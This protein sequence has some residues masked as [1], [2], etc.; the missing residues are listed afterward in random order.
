VTAYIVIQ[1]TVTDPSGFAAYAQAVAQLVADM[2]GRYIVLGGNPQ[3]LEGDYPH[4]SVVVHE[5][6]S[7]EHAL[8]FWYSPAYAEIQKLRS[9][10]GDF[11]VTLVDGH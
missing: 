9:G 5:W 1:G 3:T 4:Q 2:G 11:T 8:E 6:P 10:K 7:R